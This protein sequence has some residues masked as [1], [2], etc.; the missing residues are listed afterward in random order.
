MSAVISSQTAFETCL[1][2]Q[3]VFRECLNRVDTYSDF[4]YIARYKIIRIMF[5]ELVDRLEQCFSNVGNIA[6]RGDTNLEGALKRSGAIRRL[7][8]RRSMVSFCTGF[9]NA[10]EINHHKGTLLSV[11]FVFDSFS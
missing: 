10:G 3:R 4:E 11:I 2:R 8:G 6:P 1:Q 9:A 7:S 5:R